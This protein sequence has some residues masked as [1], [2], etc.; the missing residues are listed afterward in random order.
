M[1]KQNIIII[2]FIGLIGCL[3]SCRSAEWHL[4]KAILLNPD[5]IKTDTVFGFHLFKAP[6]LKGN[7]N[8][9]PQFLGL[10]SA[11]DQSLR[12]INISFDQKQ[13]L[14]ENIK[15]HL[16][17]TNFLPDTVLKTVDGVLFK[18]YSKNGNI[19]IDFYKP[20]TNLEAKI[21]IAINNKLQTKTPEKS[22][23]FN[24]KS[25]FIAGVLFAF[26]VLTILFFRYGKQHK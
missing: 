24:L 21:P 10:D 26:I 17:K 9:K 15:A 11:L 2:L 13:E 22:P 23:F 25:A 20:E 14:K 18:I 3:S 16:D 4:R 7:F 1:K 12:F 6:A 8:F 5:I 19:E